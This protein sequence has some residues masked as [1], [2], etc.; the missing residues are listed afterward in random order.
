[1]LV[2]VSVRIG[3]REPVVVERELCG[4]ADEIEEQVRDVGQ[5]VGRELLGPAFRE[6][7]DR[8]PTP[9]CCGR[10]M[11]NCG[12][13]TIGVMTTCGEVFV[14][15]RRYQCRCEGCH[16]EVH[17]ADARLCC[18]A[19]RVSKPL[20]KRACQLAAV[21]HFTRQIGR[22]SCRERVCLAV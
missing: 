6:I 18:G 20:A 17:P 14:R 2:Q 4:T 16:R 9:R 19:H 12:L 1:M 11:K 15:R 7:A 13:R 8:T 22:A 5:R 21:E 3:G 10:S